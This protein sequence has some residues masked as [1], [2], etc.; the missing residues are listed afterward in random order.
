MHIRLYLRTER[1]LYGT[2]VR[3]GYSVT[4]LYTVYYIFYVH[5]YV[6]NDNDKAGVSVYNKTQATYYDNVHNVFIIT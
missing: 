5:A 4:N 1:F 3:E 6:T 2:L